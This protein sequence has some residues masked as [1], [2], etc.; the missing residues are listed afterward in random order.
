MASNNCIQV[1]FCSSTVLVCR[2]H[3]EKKRTEKPLEQERIYYWVPAKDCFLC[4]KGYACELH[5]Y[6]QAREA[7]R[8]RIMDDFFF[9]KVMNK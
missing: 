3:G 8:S 4:R 6:E 1:C 2:M 7:E 9:T 5:T